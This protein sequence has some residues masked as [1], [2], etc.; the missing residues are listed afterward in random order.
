MFLG[1]KNTPSTV[2]W[3]WV[4]MIKS[5]WPWLSNHYHFTVS[6]D[7]SVLRPWH[8]VSSI[9]SDRLHELKFSVFAV[10]QL[11]LMICL[12]INQLIISSVASLHRH[13]V[14]IYLI[15][16]P[17]RNTPSSLCTCVS[18][19]PDPVWWCDRK[20]GKEIC[21]FE[22]KLMERLGH[23]QRSVYC[24][25][26]Q[27]TWSQ[28]VSEIIS[29]KGQVASISSKSA[30]TFFS[31]Y[32]RVEQQQVHPI[33]LDWHAHILCNLSCIGRKTSLYAVPI[34]SLQSHLSRDVL[35]SQN[36]G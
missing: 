35:L 13:L 9:S 34:G 19:C 17:R 29:L 12:S 21:K 26:I 7:T 32:W 3:R 25:Q 4:H 18:T 22:N 11:M 33:H 1:L 23:Y 14:L 36:F 16:T 10:F 30:T 6:S 27:Q 31:N 5:T 15:D 2:L 28:K 24:T 8:R 20:S